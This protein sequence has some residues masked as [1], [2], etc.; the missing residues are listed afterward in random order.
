LKDKNLGN[1]NNHSLLEKAIDFL[2]GQQNQQKITS[3]CFSE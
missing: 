1:E 2:H 3:S